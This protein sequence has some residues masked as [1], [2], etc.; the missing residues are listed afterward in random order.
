MTLIKLNAPTYATPAFSG[1]LDNFLGRNITE[2]AG[3]DWNYTV[4]AVNVVETPELFTVEVA[5]PGLKKEDFQVNVEHNR[6]SVSSKVEKNEEQKDG[7]YTRREFSY[8][9]F[10]RS[11]TLPNTVDAEK[12]EASYT[13][14][15]LHIS[16]PKREEAKPKPSRQISI[17]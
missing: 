4:P 10:Q 2:F 9:S 12:I 11:F 3:R 15:V 16:L 13:D 7:K 6:L 17:S 1:L 5:A 8:Q 14:G